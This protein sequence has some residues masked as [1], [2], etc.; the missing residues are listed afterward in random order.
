MRNPSDDTAPVRT[1][2]APSEADFLLKPYGG[3]RPAAPDWFRRALAAPVR[4]GETTVDGA[5]KSHQWAW[6]PLPCASNRPGFDGS[7]H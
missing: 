1:R 2:S 5:M 3:A 4:T 6:A 7:P